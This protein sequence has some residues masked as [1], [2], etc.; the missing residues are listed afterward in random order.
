MLT[1]RYSYLV[2]LFQFLYFYTEEIAKDG[3]SEE[4]I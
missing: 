4:S 2:L 1:F 3:D